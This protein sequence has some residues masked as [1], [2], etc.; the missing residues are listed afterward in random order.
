MVSPEPKSERV[1]GSPVHPPLP[2]EPLKGQFSPPLPWELATL[3]V[4]AEAVGFHMADWEKAAYA[5]NIPSIPEPPD[6][7]SAQ[8]E[9]ASSGQVSFTGATESLT[10]NLPHQLPARDK[11]SRWPL[12]TGRAAGR[13]QTSP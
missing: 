9:G 8:S 6:S 10:E 7:P 4:Q 13:E 1:A 2:T 12:A 3:F 11:D 5:A